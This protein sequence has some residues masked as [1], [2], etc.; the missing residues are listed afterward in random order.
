[1]SKKKAAA[2][3]N[4]AD[5]QPGDDPVQYV[6]QENAKVRMH[7]VQYTHQ[8]ALLLD[9]AKA[10]ELRLDPTRARDLARRILQAADAVEARLN[11]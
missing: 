7:V 3:R 2:Q 11:A 5:D 6:E 8:V 4:V 9:P 1:M 10:V